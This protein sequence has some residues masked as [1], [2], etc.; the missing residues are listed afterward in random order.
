MKIYVSHSTNFDF[1]KEL[2]TPLKKIISPSLLILPHEKNHK[3]TF[4]KDIFAQK[5]CSFILA[6]VSYPSTG[7][8]IEL[9]WASLVDIPIVCIYK[10]TAAIS[11]SLQLI[12]SRYIPYKHI[13]DIHD[14]VLQIINLL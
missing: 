7:Q 4:T 1:K 6:E 11:S 9:G 3:P 10:K 12:T 14:E 2:Y 13:S 5:K 8:G